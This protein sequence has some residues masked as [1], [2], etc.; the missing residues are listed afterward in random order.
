M[1]FV[2]FAIVAVACVLVLTGAFGKARKSR[3]NQ[4]PQDDP[5]GD[6]D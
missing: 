2:F 4:R 6:G 1:E 5:H 3:M